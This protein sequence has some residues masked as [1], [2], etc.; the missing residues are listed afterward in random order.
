MSSHAKGSVLH[1]IDHHGVHAVQLMM[2]I[3]V[4]QVLS[5]QSSQS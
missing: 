2:W 1:V 5:V 3:C 4:G